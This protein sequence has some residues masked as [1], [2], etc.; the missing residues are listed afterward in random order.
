MHA[1]PVSNTKL[2]FP[3]PPHP[4]DSTPTVSTAAATAMAFVRQLQPFILLLLSM[5][6]ISYAVSDSEILLKFKSS[7]T[8]HT[9]LKSWK[10]NSKPICDGER[11]NWTGVLCQKGSILGLKLENMGLSG[12]IDA[13]ALIALSNLR[14]LSFRNNNFN[15]SFPKFNKLT[16]LRSIYLSYNRFSGHIPGNAFEGMVRLNKLYLSKNRFTGPIP[17]SV[18]TLP[19]LWDLKLAGNRFSGEIPDFKQKGLHVVDLSNNQ[20]EGPIPASLRKMNPDM[21]AGNKGVC[22]APLKPCESTLAEP[23]GNVSPYLKEMISIWIILMPIVVGIFLLLAIVAV[24]LIIQR[25]KQQPAPKVKASSNPKTKTC[26]KVEDH[27]PVVASLS[28]TSNGTKPAEASLKL[29]FLRDEDDRDKFDLSDLLQG[30][31]EILGSGCFGASYKTTLPNGTAMVVKRYKQM[32]GAGKEDFQE[33][34]RRIGRLKHSNVLN[35]IAYYYRKEEKLLVCDFAENCSLA[36][37]LHAHQ[38]LGQPGLDWPTRLKI[39]KG[40]A[41]GLAY[42]HKELPSLVAPHG[43][44]KSSNV[45]LNKNFEPILTDYALIPVVNLETAHEFMVAYKSPEYV[46]HGRVTRKTD[47]WG[48]G[49][50]ILEIMTGKFPSNFL[51]KGKGSSEEDIVAWVKSKLGDG[52]RETL[53]TNLEVF[54]REMGAIGVGDGKTMMQLLKIGLSCCEDDV[55]K[56]LDLKEAVSRIEGLKLR[57]ISCDGD[58]YSAIASDGEDDGKW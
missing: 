21:F 4:A 42:L 44:L 53:L 56:R 28:R 1:H 24:I 54:D 7:L 17:A 49:V 10:N 26:L 6:S 40:V 50:L 46:Q 31:A 39:V 16:G 34:M 52:E 55:Q 41:K 35:L 45:L 22:G 14:T 29:T 32:N 43:H 33:H 38:T 20:L 37:H 9:A 25:K 23:N 18:A 8:N 48:L 15:G 19:K 51:L 36:V 5:V 27:A 47:V 58:F 13:N 2:V 11:T 12:T 57:N 3:L 30:S